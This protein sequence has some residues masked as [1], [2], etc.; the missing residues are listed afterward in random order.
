MKWHKI[1]IKYDLVETEAKVILT[2]MTSWIIISDN[3]FA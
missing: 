3:N 2:N 1:M